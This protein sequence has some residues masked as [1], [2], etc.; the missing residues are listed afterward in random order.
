MSA[1]R[2]HIGVDHAAGDDLNPSGVLAHTASLGIAKNTDDVEVESGLN[3]WVECGPEP[4]FHLAAHE[5][6]YQAFQRGL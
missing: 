2:Q 4:C 3:E 6:L 5:S 1:C